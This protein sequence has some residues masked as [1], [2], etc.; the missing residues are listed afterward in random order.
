M[1]PERHN[2]V[3]VLLFLDV[4]GSMSDHIQLCEQLFSA[5]RSEFRHLEHFY[6]HNFIYEAVWRD[7]R[8]RFNEHVATV[9]VMRTY[10]PD[11]KVLFVG[12][13]TMSPYEI[14]QEGGSIEHFNGEPGAVW[15]SRLRERY[16]RHAWL[17]PEP[18]QRWDYT[19][20]IRLV[21]ELVEDRMFPLTPEGLDLA[22]R[23]VA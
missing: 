21:R 4:G 1:I 6:F 19:P 15:M 3:K 10:G 8:R 2:A 20:S 23:A 14:T 5:A 12:D 9:E 22:M 16:P 18:P 17:N 13:A 11:Y 7:N